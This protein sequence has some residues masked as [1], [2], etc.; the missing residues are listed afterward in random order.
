MHAV[1]ERESR[2]SLSKVGKYIR[3]RLGRYPLDQKK[4][5]RLFPVGELVIGYRHN[6]L[7]D[8]LTKIS[9]KS[10]PI[11]RIVPFLSRS[12]VQVSNRFSNQ[13]RDRA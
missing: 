10:K 4:S 2:T 1:V 13:R 7:Q 3:G 6:S 11:L 5:L 9:V 12:A 8:R